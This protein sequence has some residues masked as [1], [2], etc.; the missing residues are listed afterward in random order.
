M[1]MFRKAIA[2]LLTASMALGIAGCDL[3]G[4]RKNMGAVDGVIKEYATAI[5][6]LDEGKVL[7]LTCFDESDSGY[8]EIKDC[9]VFDGNADYI[10]DVYTTTASTIALGVNSNSIKIDGD[11]KASIDFDYTIVDWKPLFEGSSE[12]S[13]DL[14]KAI[15][16]SN[17][18]NTIKGGLEFKKVGG[19]WKISKIR[20]LDELLAFTQVWPNLQ[21]TEWPTIP[22]ETDYT[23]PYGD[24][25][26]T[27]VTTAFPDSYGKAI[28]AYLEL[29]EKNKTA[30]KEIEEKYECYPVG[31]F[32][33]NEDGIPELLFLA[34]DGVAPAYRGTLYVYTYNEYAGEAVKVIEIPHVIYMAADGGYFLLYKTANRIIV[35]HAGGSE[36]EFEYFTEIYN[37]QWNLI[38]SY[39]R[40][41]LT[42]IS[43][44]DE[45]VT[46]EYYRND[47]AITE[48][49][50]NKVFKEDVANTT[51]IL[52]KNYNPAPDDVEYPLAGKPSFELMGYETAYAYVKSLKL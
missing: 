24:P 13:A 32:D 12:S 45:T 33:I 48:E 4:V 31:V 49:E 43:D 9:F 16:K 28:N 26:P 36:V 35:T 37:L 7:D 17:D 14:V 2:T 39:R 52:A 46:Y 19:E 38:D 30:I 21:N 8:K 1:Q 47:A 5:N 42:Y 23:A 15:K 20:N 44:Y 6:S 27:A 10:R 18:F 11:N 51:V 29:L 40:V 22:T 25:D 3:F 50:Y 34:S 41:V